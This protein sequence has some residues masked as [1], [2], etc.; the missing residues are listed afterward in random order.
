MK[1]VFI[2]IAGVMALAC[3]SLAQ[4]GTP[5]TPR[6][7]QLI[8]GC[9]NCSAAYR[10]SDDPKGAASGSTYR[11]VTATVVRGGV[12]EG[13]DVHDLTIDNVQFTLKAD[14]TGSALPAGG[15]I[16]G[17]AHDVLIFNSSATNFR[18]VCDPKH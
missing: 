8:D 2:L 18:M 13:G 11:N 4:A 10:V 3:A 15:E 9:P 14:K 16:Q 5:V 7:A 1:R 17:T 6:A 12:R